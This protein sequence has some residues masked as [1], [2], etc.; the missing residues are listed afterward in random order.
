MCLYVMDRIVS[1]NGVTFLCLLE[2][3][4]VFYTVVYISPKERARSGDA[5]AY[6]MSGPVGVQ[7][8]VNVTPHFIIISSVIRGAHK[9][10]C[11]C[12]C[13]CSRY[14]YTLWGPN[15]PKI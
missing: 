5:G 7:L 12:V 9:Y 6:V 13:V 4:T 11:V 15:V 10:V 1:A 8:P 3:Y 2:N 14:T